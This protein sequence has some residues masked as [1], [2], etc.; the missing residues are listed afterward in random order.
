MLAL[1]TVPMGMITPSE[2]CCQGL[3]CPA[4]LP[5]RGVM[6]RPAA[7][8]GRET[9]PP[10]PRCCA[11]AAVLHFS[12]DT[13]ARYEYTVEEDCSRAVGFLRSSPIARSGSR[14]LGVALGP[15]AVAVW[16]ETLFGRCGRASGVVC[17][18]RLGVMPGQMRRGPQE[19]C[20]QIRVTNRERIRLLLTFFLI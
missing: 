12:L 14:P 9:G 11:E 7:Q 15:M 2:G 5:A 10:G 1:P 6:M 8:P 17:F 16:A 4:G 20:T 19:R 3:S 18:G 13:R